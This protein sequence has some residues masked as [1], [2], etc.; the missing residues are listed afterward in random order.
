MVKES[1]YVF[2]L[3]LLKEVRGRKIR[4]G[5]PGSLLLSSSIYKATSFANLSQ[6]RSPVEFIRTLTMY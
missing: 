4:M 1:I 3:E 5:P 2:G 6:K